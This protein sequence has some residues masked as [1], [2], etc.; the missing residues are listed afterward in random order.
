MRQQLVAV[1]YRGKRYKGI[2]SIFYPTENIV[3]IP[4]WSE[5][6]IVY[7]GK[8]CLQEFKSPY[9]KPSC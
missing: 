6:A 3:Y 1:I 8:Y 2:R 4:L 9:A 7:I 5:F